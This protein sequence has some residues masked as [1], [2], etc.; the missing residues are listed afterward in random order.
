MMVYQGSGVEKSRENTFSSCTKVV[1]GVYLY[2]N[3]I[4]FSYDSRE[5][6]TIV[7]GV[8]TKLLTIG[9]LPLST[10]ILNNDLRVICP[11][12]ENPG[13]FLEIRL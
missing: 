6:L 9:Y 8:L 7:N 5:M 1:H 10:G 12:L 3:H 4:L 13:G 11:N 2:T